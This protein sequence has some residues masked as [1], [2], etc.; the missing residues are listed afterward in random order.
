MSKRLH[1]KS[2][3]NKSRKFTRKHRGGAQ[4][5]GWEPGA[6]LVA[7]LNTGDQVHRVY[8]SCMSVS[9]PGQI[10]YSATGGLPGMR[11][12]AYTNN[13]T[14]N[15][16]GFPQIDKVACQPNPTNP[17]NQ[18]GGVGLQAASA[19]PVLESHN[20]RYTTAPSQWTGSTGAPVLLNQPLNASL[21]SKACTQTA[22]RR[23]MKKSR[24]SKSRKSKSRKSK[25]R[26]SKSRKSRKSRK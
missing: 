7:G 18:H 19:S 16:G 17:L 24:K 13:L 1:K 5:S 22:G 2:R 14:A 25:S 26:K 10:S 6:P 12:G 3:G 11:G 23:N 8:D 20:A 21:W 4:G 15:Y 9:R